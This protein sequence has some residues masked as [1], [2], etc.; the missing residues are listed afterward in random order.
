MERSSASQA[1][2]MKVS[3]KNFVVYGKASTS[4]PICYTH[5]QFNKVGFV[6]MNV[7]LIKRVV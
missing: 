2:A 5:V 4:T 7:V 1:V 6:L 3:D